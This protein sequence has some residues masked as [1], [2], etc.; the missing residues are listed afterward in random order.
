[1]TV[2]DLF[3]GIGADFGLVDHILLV[4]NDD[5]LSQWRLTKV[6]TFGVIL[7]LDAAKIEKVFV[8]GHAPR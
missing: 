3:I 7:I 5:G 6:N 8:N 2:I 4:I 1:M